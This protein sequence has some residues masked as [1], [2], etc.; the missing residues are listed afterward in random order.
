MA[1]DVAQA[2]I[3]LGDIDAGALVGVG[4][5]VV[6]AHDRRASVASVRMQADEHLQFGPARDCFASLCNDSREVIARSRSDGAIP[7]ERILARRALDPPDLARDRAGVADRLHEMHAVADLQLVEIA[8][9]Q[10]VA[11]EIE[12]R[13]LVRQK[14]AMILVRDRAATPGRRRTRRPRAPLRRRAACA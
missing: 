8:L 14:E 12:L 5:S 1:H 7:V 9:H 13:A 2:R 11:V 4:L 10:A 6:V 3:G